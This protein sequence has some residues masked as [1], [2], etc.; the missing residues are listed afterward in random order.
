MFRFLRAHN[1][2]KVGGQQRR[3]HAAALACR[4]EAETGNLTL[5]RGTATISSG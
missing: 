4:T 3:G 1:I 2:P 5:L